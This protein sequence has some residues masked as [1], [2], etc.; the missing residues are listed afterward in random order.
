MTI[1]SKDLSGP[2]AYTGVARDEMEKKKEQ[3]IN[4]GYF[5]QDSISLNLR[6]LAAV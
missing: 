5:M 6:G 2:E 4:K 1:T 3:L